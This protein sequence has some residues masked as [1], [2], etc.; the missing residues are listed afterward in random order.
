MKIIVL[1]TCHNR[2]DKTLDCLRLLAAQKPCGAELEV[3]VVDDGSTD[4]TAEAIATEFPEVRILEGDGSLYWCGGMRMAWRAAAEEDP[5]Y[6]LLLNDDTHL[7]PDALQTISA[8]SHDHED[9]AIVVGAICDPDTGEVTY[10]G[11][12]RNI[13]LIAPN[14]KTEWCDTFNA[15]CVLIPRAVYACL[16]ILHHRYTHGLGDFDYG[17]QATKRGIRIVQTARYVGTCK[18]DSVQ[19]TWCDRSL[20]RLRRLQL[21]QSPKGLPC[22]EWLVF[23]LRNSGWKWPLYFLS[24]F[25]RIILGR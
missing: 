9:K 1:I 18:N 2:R 22:R 14:G 23:N 4:G 8:V 12:R 17:M 13:G 15:N 11:V 7:F 10:G 19:G 21:L 6:Y 20:P 5:D 25:I 16:G 24:P 3:I